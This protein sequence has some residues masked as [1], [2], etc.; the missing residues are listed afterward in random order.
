MEWWLELLIIVGGFLLLA[1]TGM[2]VAFAFLIVAGLGAFVWW[3]GG[4]GLEQLAL[5]IY[6]SITL[7]AIVPLPLFILMGELLFISGMANNMI[8]AVDRWIGRVP[9][10]LGLIAVGGGALLG[11]L[12]GASMGSVAMLGSQLVPEMQ[13][14]GYKKPM[15]L[16][17]ILGSGGLAM[18]I[19]PSAMAVFL[20]A[21]AGVSIA[22]LLMAIIIPGILMAFL[23]GSYI[24][25]RSIVQPSVA[26][27]YVP[28][29]TPLKERIILFLK[30]VAPIGIVI[31]L[32]TGVIFLG[33]ATPSEAAATGC[34]GAII[35]AAIYKKLSWQVLKKSF[36]K[37]TEISVMIFTIIVAAKGFS[38]ILAFTGA[39]P[40]LVAIV[41]Y[42]DVPPLVIVFV[43]MAIL[44]ILGM[45][46]VPT[47]MIFVSLP[48]FMPIIDALG[49]SPV[50][51]ATL[52]MLNLEMA[53]T[54]PPYGINLFVM[55]DVGP[56]GTTMG[57]CIRAAIPFL[58]LDA[59]ALIL[60]AVFPDI[61]L[62]LPDI[63]GG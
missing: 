25:G 54:T 8:D 24:V 3:G 43:M 31:F 32:V 48:V 34:L 29:P 6:D 22:S 52:F 16:G 21:V 41:N 5:S 46:I 33:V 47:A 50:W 18:M 38:Q 20:G 51:F 62:W 40:E 53:T 10:R 1:S 27:V 7:F 23:Y 35:L 14:R 2:P 55:K 26:P 58:I 13:K 56:P 61:A 37:T 28:P 19:P 60:I 49:F 42:I 4:V 15:T 59:I 30:Y 63:M 17:P 44:L 57:D 9:G 12:T 45:F 36:I 11:F 39:T